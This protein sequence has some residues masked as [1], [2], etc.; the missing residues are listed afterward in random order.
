MKLKKVC[1]FLFTMIACILSF[2]APQ[3]AEASEYDIMP[4]YDYTRQASSSLSINSSGKATVSISCTGISGKVSK[5]TAETCLQR[6]VG[7]IWVKVD[8]GTTNNVWTD[9]T[10]N[11]YLNSSHSTTVSKSGTYRAK[12]VFKVYN[13]STKSESITIY[14][15]TVEYN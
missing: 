11:Y 3:V 15:N 8:I 13:T 7:L 9:S 1:C 2:L 10:T 6:K 14:S 5:I 4:Y 12:T